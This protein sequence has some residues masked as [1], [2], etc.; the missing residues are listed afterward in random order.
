MLQRLQTIWLLLA[1]LAALA[2]LKLPSY[3]I[4]AE[5][6]LQYDELNGLNAGL[7]VLLVTIAIGVL[8]FITIGLYKNRTT[9][10]RLCV[11]GIMLEALLIFLYYRQTTTFIKGTPSVYSI[12]HMCIVLFFVL[13]ARGINK[14]EKLIKDSDRLR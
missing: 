12:L 13:A 6:N 5:V 4:A 11:A 1:G 7:P 14:D 8:A 9:Q 10:L 3:A 2:T